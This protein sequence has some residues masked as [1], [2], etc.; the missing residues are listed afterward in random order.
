[1][2]QARRD[3]PVKMIVPN[4]FAQVM[5]FS[6]FLFLLFNQNRTFF[7][8]LPTGAEDYGDKQRDGELIMQR[9]LNHNQ[10]NTIL[11]QSLLNV[12]RFGPGVLGCDWTRELTHAFIKSEPQMINYNGVEVESRSGSE[13]QEFVKYEGNLVRPVSPYRWFPDTR[14]PLTEFQRG[15]FCASEER[16]LDFAVT[17]D[18]TGW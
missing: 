9:D 3:K 18:G 14:F 6:S 8:L 15:E 13:W 17:S 5:T 1:M 16:V 10:W 2:T 12:G 4:T 11:F 7:E